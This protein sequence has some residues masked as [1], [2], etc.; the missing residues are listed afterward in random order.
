MMPPWNQ[1][2]NGAI[3][4][5]PVAAQRKLPSLSEV[6]RKSEREPRLLGLAAPMRSA[7]IPPLSAARW[8]LVLIVA[9]GIYFFHG[10]LV[11]GPGS[12]GHRLCQLAALPATAC[13]RRRQPHYRRDFR[14]PVHPDLPGRADRARR[15]LCHRRGPRMGRLGDRDQSPRRADAALDRHHADRR[16]MAERAMGDQFWPPRRRSAN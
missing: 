2:G 3:W 9:A 10:F 14:D 15:H 16:R 5:C 11:S 4:F 6:K 8:L 1:A 7:L 13:R 12:T